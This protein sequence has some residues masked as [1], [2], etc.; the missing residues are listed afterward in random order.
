ME[1]HFHKLYRAWQLLTRSADE[2]GTEA[3]RFDVADV[4]REFLQVAPCA[5]AYLCAVRALKTRS[6]PALT[7]A[8]SAMISAVMDIDALLSSH[9]S[10]VLG[11]HLRDARALGHT[12]SE[13]DLM[14]WNQRSQVTLWVPYGPLDQPPHMTPNLSAPHSLST[15]ATKQWGGLER[16]IHAERFR[17]FLKQAQDDL[18]RGTLNLTKYLTDVG[19]L[20]VQWENTRWDPHA[21]PDVAVGDLVAISRTLQRKYQ[22]MGTGWA[23]SCPTTAA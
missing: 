12:Q 23:S 2:C 22:L 13:S 9:I 15:Y 14:E 5:E 3:A 1:P 8:G 10:F 17:L 19:A 18:P 21:L 7:A 16:T 4:G 11:A 20:G 6:A